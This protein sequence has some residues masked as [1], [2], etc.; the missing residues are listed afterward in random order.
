MTPKKL[1][2]SSP[3]IAGRSFIV[4]ITRG[5]RERMANARVD[6]NFMILAKPRQRSPESFDRCDLDALVLTG[7]QAEYRA[8]DGAELI[9]VIS[10]LP[11]VN[12]SCIQLVGK[13][14][15]SIE[16]PAA[17]KTPTK[18]SYLRRT[19]CRTDKFVGAPDIGIRKFGIPDHIEHKLARFRSVLRDL[20]AVKI[21][22]KNDV[23]LR[24]KPVC[25]GANI[26][27]EPPPFMN[28]DYCWQRLK[29]IRRHHEVAVHQLV[30]YFRIG[31]IL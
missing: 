7:E 23:S 3:G 16:R 11:I 20:A 18:R 15:R 8:I 4:V 21:N 17:A 24:G 10:Y 14:L 30:I 6:V 9:L 2:R 5:V 22:S 26:V 28:H 25:H 1:E 19:R 13:K 27:V 12:D 29:H 31:Q